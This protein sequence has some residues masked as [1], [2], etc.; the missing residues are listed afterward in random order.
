MVH[1]RAAEDSVPDIPEEST[2]CGHSRG[3]APRGNPPPT[4][5]RAPVSIEQI[6][7]TQNELMSVP[8]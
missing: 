4:P 7:A 1:T 3:Q 8:V 2:S 6:L 5:P